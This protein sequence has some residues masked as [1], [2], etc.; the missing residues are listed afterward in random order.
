VISTGTETWTIDSTDPLSPSDIVKS[1]SVATKAIK[2]SRQVVEGEGVKGF[3]DYVDYVRHPE[4]ALGYSLSGTVVSV[5]RK[6]REITVGDRVACAGEGKASHAELVSVPRNLLAK[7]PDGVEM[8]HAAFSTIGAIALHAFRRSGAQVGD[9]VGVVG[10]G[11]VGNILAQI[12]GASGCKV[13]SLDLRDDRLQ[14]AKEVGVDL[15]LR[16]DDPSLLQH[17]SHF[18]NGRGLD[19]VFICAATSSSDPIN[20]AASMARGKAKV[21]VVGR[22]G[23]DLQRKDF[24]QKEL[25][26]V[27]TR[28]LGPGR[29]DPT[30]EEK[31]V[32]YPIEHVRWTLNRNME[33]FLELLRTGRVKLNNLIGAEYDVE[34]A[35]EAYAFLNEQSKVA[36]L[37]K[38]EKSGEGRSP[39]VRDGG[40]G[41]GRQAVEKRERTANV[42]SVSGKINV[43]LVGPGNFAKEMLMPLLR[44]SPEYNLRWVV[45]SNPVNATRVQKRYGFEKATCDYD[46]VLKDRETNLVVISTPNNMHYRMVMDA[47]EADKPVFVEKPLCVTRQEF[48]D[49]KKAQSLHQ[50]PVIVGFNRR[51]SPLVLKVKDKMSKMDGPFLM[52]LRVNAGFVPA[53]RWIQDPALSGGRII[54][55]CCHFFDLFNFLLDQSDPEILVQTAGV[56]GSTTVARDNLAVT[57][58][59]PD[60]SVASLIYTALGGKSMDRERLEVFGQGTSMVIDDFKELKTYGQVPTRT[61]LKGQEKGH[62]PEFNELSK[63]L[64]GEK[65]TVITTDEVIAATELTFRVDE[66][67]REPT[68][69]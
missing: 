17:I 37:L 40:G 24:Y 12:A 26:L 8:R 64:H 58:K 44:R 35:D 38:Y 9:A 13:V 49:I 60:G 5:G 15:C 3:L 32:D 6:V 7:V 69:N 51:Y 29:Y 45:S 14:L 16:S 57:L 25:D 43:A 59:Y 48:E 63:L 50:V 54:H 34:R 10:A 2:L 22:V 67:L 55:E 33:G 47:I 23:M 41:G 65:S 52:T 36:V 21:V 31:G 56:N 61:T 62:A 53:S 19:S 30:Y 28:S 11:L 20:L 39:A 68:P 46:D 27:M 4:M 1:S 42:P 66:A 18:T